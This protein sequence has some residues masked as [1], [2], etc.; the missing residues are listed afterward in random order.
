MTFYGADP[1]TDVNA[2]LYAKIGKYFPFAVGGDAGVSMASVY[3]NGSY[4][5]RDVVH[6]DLVYFLDRILKIKVSPSHESFTYFSSLQTYDNIWLDAEGAEYGLLD[7]FYKSG[8]L[9]EHGIRFCQMSL[10]MHKPSELRQL[11][12]MQMIKTIVR[13]QRYGMHKNRNVGHMR[14]FLFNFADA[15]CVRKFL[16]RH[17]Y[18]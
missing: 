17:L 13:E 5:K 12:F 15:Y 2:D 7:I 10:E 18:E 6:V 14:M 16:A 3:V 8:R 9:D 11:Q 4:V 1:I